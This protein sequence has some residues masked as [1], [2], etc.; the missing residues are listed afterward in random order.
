MQTNELKTIAMERRL[1]VLEVV[2]RSKSGHIGGAMSGLDILVSLYYVIMDVEKIKR[3]DPDRDRFVMSKG[4]CGDSLYTV[5]ADCGFFAKELLETYAAFDTILAEHPTKKVPGVEM[6]TGALGHGLPLAVG[7]A[8]A[9]KNDASPANVYVFMGD[10]EQAEGSNWE[11]AM[12]ASK[13]GLGNL[14]AVIDRNYLQIS[15]STEEVMPIDNLAAKYSAF[16]WQVKECNG[17]EPTEIIE[18]ISAE[19]LADQPLLVIAR[20]TK[21]YGSAVM[22]N[23]ASWHHKTP[24]QEE[25]RQIKVDLQEQIR[26]LRHD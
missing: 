8:I 6:A 19:R 11:A 23:K 12:A 4:H 22:A 24:S 5:L 3:Q 21:G 16:G 18:A 15:G 25:Y 9:C 17:H 1:D 14:T 10:G 20:T 7:M 2:M 26:G 13:Y